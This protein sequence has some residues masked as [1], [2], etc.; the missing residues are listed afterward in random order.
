MRSDKNFKRT[1]CAWCAF[2]YVVSGTPS[3]NR[4]LC[5]CSQHTA[6]MPYTS[7]SRVVF[8][9]DDREWSSNSGHECK[10]SNY[11]LVREN[12]REIHQNAHPALLG[13]C[14]AWLCSFG[15]EHKQTIRSA[16]KRNTCRSHDKVTGIIS[17]LGQTTLRAK[18]PSTFPTC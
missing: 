10:K 17:R 6:K 4:S 12:S 11:H 7:S 15:R 8:V 9:C 3:L 16:E 14:I 1:L 13:G 2:Q 18:R 5:M